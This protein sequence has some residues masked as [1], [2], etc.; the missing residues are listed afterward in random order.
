MSACYLCP[1]GTKTQQAC[2]QLDLGLLSVEQN[3]SVLDLRYTSPRMYRFAK[4]GKMPGSSSHVRSTVHS[5][6]IVLSCTMHAGGSVCVTAG[7]MSVCVTAGFMS[8]C[9][10]AGFMSVCVT[11]GF[12]SVC[13]TA[14]LRMGAK[15]CQP[16]REAAGQAWW[17]F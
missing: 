10:T 6:E 16:V 7:F 13:V 17:A 12:M 15:S 5:F 4:P 2:H 1:P 11:A 8:V 14:G 9:V 3:S